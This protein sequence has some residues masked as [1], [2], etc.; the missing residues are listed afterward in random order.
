MKNEQVVLD[1]SE[2]GVGRLLRVTSNHGKRRDAAVGQVGDTSLGL[3][4]GVPAIR[5]L[6]LLASPDA[7]ADLT[8]LTV[9]A[10]ADAGEFNDKSDK[11][12]FDVAVV[13]VSCDTRWPVDAARALYN[14][15]GQRF[16]VV[17]LFDHKSDATVVEGDAHDRDV[18]CI[19]KDA[20]RPSELGT[21]VSG[22]ATLRRVRTR[23]PA[24]S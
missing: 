5:V 9:T 18:Y 11:G 23:H 10:C 16:V 8:P 2:L 17:L 15:L 22:V 13:D 1:D 6:A 3:E 4:G 21:I 19:L 7:E 20:L 14:R 12:H 24:T